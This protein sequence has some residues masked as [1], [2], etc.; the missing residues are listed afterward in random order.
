VAGYFKNSTVSNCYATGTVSA[1]SSYYN[2]SAAGG[3]AGGMAEST[4]SNC[5]STGTVN[6]N[7][8]Y[9]YATS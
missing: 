6:A 5:Y 4:V 1:N 7:S 2:T 8:T 9:S 3:F